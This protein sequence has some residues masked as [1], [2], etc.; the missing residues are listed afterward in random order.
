MKNDFELVFTSNLEKDCFIVELWHNDIMVC[1]LY[2]DNNVVFYN[3][4]HASYNI[5]DLI[6]SLL[7]AKKLLIQE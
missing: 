5:D 1:E 6:S 3:E 4:K 7:K 2:E